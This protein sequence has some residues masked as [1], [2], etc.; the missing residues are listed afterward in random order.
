MLSTAR[1]LIIC[2]FVP[3]VVA[4][5]PV[6]ASPAPGSGHAGRRQP[7]AHCGRQQGSSSGHRLSPFSLLPGKFQE[8]LFWGDA[9]E[10]IA[11]TR[12]YGL[13]K[14]PADPGGRKRS[15]VSPRDHCHRMPVG[16][17]WPKAY[18]RAH[19]EPSVFRVDGSG[20]RVLGQPT[21]CCGTL[22]PQRTRTR[23]GTRALHS[24]A[25]AWRSICQAASR[26]CSSRGTL[27]RKALPMGQAVSFYFSLAITQ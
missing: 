12:S 27:P 4:G 16:I 5:C 14:G 24:G 3:I 18:T 2:S 19:E 13:L 26:V 15:A 10:A 1:P 6:Q 25:P 23:T 17:E 11:V 9:F 21:D 22:R 7:S 8:L 20:P